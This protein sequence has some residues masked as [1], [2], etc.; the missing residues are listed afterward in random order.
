MEVIRKQIPVPTNNKAIIL[1]PLGD[2]HLGAKNCDVN[3][4]KKLLKWCEK[5]PNVY[6]LGMGDYADCIYGRDKRFDLEAVDMKYSTP[7]KQQEALIKWLSPL[8]GRI[9][10]LLT[11]NHEESI[12]KV[13]GLDITRN[14]AGRLGVPYLGIS[15]FVQL[16]FKAKNGKRLHRKPVIMYAH[17][18]YF[19]G[20]SSGGKVN[21]LLSLPKAYDADVYL[22]GH[23]HD[24]L[25]KVEEKV[26]LE[27]GK[28]SKKRIVYALTGTL[29]KTVTQGGRGYGEDKG[30]FPTRTGTVS[31][32]I[33]PLEQ[34]IGLHV[35][36]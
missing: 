21:N 24:I 19:G 20:R 28:L 4:L 34:P 16:S 6:I 17:H 18:G 5:H 2:I 1:K 25:T 26:C 13:C 29:L 32:K 22:V 35:S 3:Y 31:V 10:G 9:I 14:I 11:G 36:E 8:K 23:C 30:Y 27:N 15:A 33:L 7:E 12:R